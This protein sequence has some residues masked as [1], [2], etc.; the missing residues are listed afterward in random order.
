MGANE[1]VTVRPSNMSAGLKTS[2]SGKSD[3]IEAPQHLVDS[4]KANDDPMYRAWLR[5]N[6]AGWKLPVLIPADSESEA[7]GTAQE[8]VQTTLNALGI[9]WEEKRLDDIEVRRII[10]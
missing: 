1:H 10:D 4:V 9:P 7:L 2:V 6:G 3:P 5:R 8:I